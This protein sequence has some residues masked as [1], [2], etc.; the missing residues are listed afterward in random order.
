M[1]WKHFAPHDI[2]VGELSSGKFRLEMA[3]QLGINFEITTNLPV[4]DGTMC[5]SPVGVE[6]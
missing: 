1:S 5:K 4:D 3:K 2:A 6:L